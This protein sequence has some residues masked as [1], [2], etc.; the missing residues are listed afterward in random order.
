MS[1]TPRG[2]SVQEAY[3]EFRSRNFKVN[4]RYQRKLVWTEEEKEKL[5]DSILQ[6]Y[7]IPLFLLA[8][9]DK[10]RGETGYEILDGLQRLDAIFSYI[11][12]NFDIEGKFFDVTQLSRANNLAK[13]GSINVKRDEAVLLSP[14]SCANI[15]DY[16]LAVT[17]FPS[18]DERD[19]NEVFSRINS[20]GRN[21]SS[22]DRRQA[23]VVNTFANLVR[24]LAQDI[25][26]DSSPD[27]LDLSEMSE[28]SID[29]S[30]SGQSYG[31]KAKE[32][33]WCKEN[34]MR[35]K[36]L[37][38]SHDE[39]FLADVVV[40]VLIDEPFPYRREKMDEVYEKGTNRYNKIDE[41][42]ALYGADKLENDIWVTFQ[43]IKKV[44]ETH[45]YDKNIR[46]IVNPGSSNPVKADFYAI[47]M[48][49][50][51]LIINENKKPANPDKIID[52][53]KGVHDSLT[54][55][56][57][58][59]N[60]SS[61]R[62]NINTIKGRIQDHFV[63]SNDPVAGSGQKLKKNIERIL[64][65]SRI[66]NSIYECKQG[67]VNLGGSFEVDKSLLK[68]IPQTICGIA[69]AKS[70]TEG[71]L[72]FGVADTVSDSERIEKIY[73]VKSIKVGNR[74]VV[75]IDRESAKLEMGLEDYESILIKTIKESKLSSHL[76]S[77]VLGNIE[78]FEYRSKYITYI[79]IPTQDSLSR[80]GE[81]VFTREGSST[82]KVTGLD[83]IFNVKEKVEG[84]R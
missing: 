3:R 59:K 60:K 63:K 55:G 26:G 62:N 14:E 83:D 28:I 80:V 40:S 58:S 2:M 72:I 34:I 25:R 67:I 7:P 15:L 75:G 16:Q 73:D 5:I 42:I 56:R 61:R 46:D 32:T 20:Y 10:E 50:Y 8:R 31:I 45:S 9:V 69:N 27:K 44:F 23:G 77:D 71:A 47:F 17:I 21:L 6:G 22:Q 30:D 12:N 43:E 48:A 51:D 24:K 79:R 13:N 4:R 38:D 39:Q 1:V 29:V 68:R 70:D 49:F 18:D 74:Y 84:S 54:V 11:E 64:Q 41:K 36:H 78:T 65:R 19:I 33:F 53:I 37:R 82:V 52:N 66:E 35:K 81:N 57:G 76:K